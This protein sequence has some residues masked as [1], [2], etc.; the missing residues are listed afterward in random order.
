[1]IRGILVTIQVMFELFCGY[2]RISI[3]RVSNE[4]RSNIILL[5]G[6][7]EETL[8]QQ[9]SEHILWPFGDDYLISLYF[10]IYD[11][12]MS[13]GHLNAAWLIIDKKRRD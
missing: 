4:I 12:I 1:M 7:K 8:R 3:K 10:T 2:K 5:N 11:Y 9:N 6:H 13:I